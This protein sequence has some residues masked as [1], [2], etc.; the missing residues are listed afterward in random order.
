[1]IYEY[2][3]LMAIDQ[4]V[5]GLIRNLRTDLQFQ[6]G[7]NPKRW[8]G[9][10][11]KNTLARALQ[12]SNSIEGINA[13]LAEAVAIIDNER[14]DTL[15]DETIDALKG[16]RNAMTYII[17]T[18]G[19]RH[20]DVNAQLIRSLHF[21]ML[22]Y[23]MSKLPGQWRNGPIFVVRE[24]T[25]DTEY[26]APHE[27]LVP[28]LISELVNQI[29]SA[30]QYDS[31]TVLGAM[32]H[33]NLTMIHPFK[34]G[35]GRMARAL[36][37]LVISK[38]GNTSPIF[39]SIEEWLGSNTEA[40]YAIL[41]ETGQGKWSPQNSALPWVRFCLTAHFQQGVNLK[42]RNLQIGRVLE[43]VSKIIKLL[44]LP[45]RAEAPLMD[46]AFGY[47]VRNST[48]RQEAGI[49]EVVASRDFKKLTEADYLSAIGEKRG[50]TYVASEKLKSV[51]V[52][53]RS[54]ITVVEDPYS[55]FS[56]L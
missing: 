26:E 55:S 20:M 7:Q 48:Y 11:R 40:Y 52:N 1:L 45:D 2:P 9:F 49:S 15:E 43:E 50:R 36:Q 10:L 38:T 19:D 46:A 37:T 53:V 54:P 21:M 4:E 17:S 51:L 22:N 39:C 30:D 32:A 29:N 35:N 41:K 33:L 44:G 13:N 34:D 27:D 3:K 8:T 56:R 16:Y 12:G 25:N 5:L 6:V 14:P 47:R 24:N 42:K 28:S 23:D 31:S 18:H